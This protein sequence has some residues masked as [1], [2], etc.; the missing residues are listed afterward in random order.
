MRPVASTVKHEEV[1]TDNRAHN[2]PRSVGLLEAAPASVFRD[3]LTSRIQ[4]GG[5]IHS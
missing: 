3:I 5:R 4:A 2:D 1:G